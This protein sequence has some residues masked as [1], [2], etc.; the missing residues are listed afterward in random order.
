MITLIIYGTHH[1][2]QKRV[3]FRTDVCLSCG[4]EAV[5]IEFRTFDVGHVYWLPLLPFGFRRHWQCSA[6]GEHPRGERTGQAMKVLGILAFLGIGV[7]AWV[8]SIPPEDLSFAWALR[9]GGPAVAVALAVSMRQRQK[10]D[11]GLVARLRRLA[12][13]GDA[14]PLCGG[15]V[16]ASKPRRCVKC[17]AVEGGAPELSAA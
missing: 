14:C 17:A 12:P 2:A 7:V 6:C 16:S 4:K 1:F 15:R 11:M 8:A 3:G 10:Q 13:L 9:L 5:A